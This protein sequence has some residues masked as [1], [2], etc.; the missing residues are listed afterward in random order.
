MINLC[1]NCLK[2]YTQAQL[3]EIIEMKQELICF[4]IFKNKKNKKNRLKK[5]NLLFFK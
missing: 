5:N 1:P 2:Q 3:K 4:H